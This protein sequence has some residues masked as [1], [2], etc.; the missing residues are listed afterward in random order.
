MSTSGTR[1]VLDHCGGH[2][3]LPPAST[4]PPPEVALWR[5]G[6][7]TLAQLPN[8]WCKISGL[9]GAQGGTEGAGGAV[10]WS[11][12]LQARGPRRGVCCHVAPLRGARAVLRA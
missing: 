2:H 9:Q 12:E 3:Q 4:D 5:A 6:I 1:F 10:G 7:M 11:A 8:V